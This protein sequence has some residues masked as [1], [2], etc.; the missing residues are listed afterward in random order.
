MA[1]RQ[2]L[3][4]LLQAMMDYLISTDTSIQKVFFLWG[5]PPLRDVA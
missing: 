4:D 2:P 1:G 3:V 5:P